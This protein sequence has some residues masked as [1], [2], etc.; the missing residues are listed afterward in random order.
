VL[1]SIAAERRALL[2][3][4]EEGSTTRYPGSVE[5]GIRKGMYIEVRETIFDNAIAR[6]T[7]LVTC[8]SYS[9]SMSV[10]MSKIAALLVK[11][12]SLSSLF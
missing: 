10:N 8:L 5:G 4:S 6:A 9:Q 12:D 3:H 11:G 7:V 2:C 1:V